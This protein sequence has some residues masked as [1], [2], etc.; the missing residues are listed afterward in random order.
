MYLNDNN[1]IYDVAIIGCGPAGLSAA[2]NA[3]R[4]N[5][6]I[7][8]LGSNFCSPKMYKALEINNYLGFYDIS[9]KELRDIFLE[10]VSEMGI[11]INRS[12][13]DNIYDQGNYYN[14]ITRNRSLQAYSVVL[15]VG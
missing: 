14:L 4:R 12:K 1:D 3:K 10:H 13:V 11:E 5:V 6:N 2:I 9:G 7:I 8:L 15:A